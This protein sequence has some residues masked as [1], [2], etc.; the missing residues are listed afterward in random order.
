MSRKSKT[1][2]KGAKRMKMIVKSILY[3]YRGTFLGGSKSKEHMERSGTVSSC[4]LV[5][6]VF[7][8]KAKVTINMIGR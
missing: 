3:T 7:K 1:T 2:K 5:N 8:G 4:F 6:G